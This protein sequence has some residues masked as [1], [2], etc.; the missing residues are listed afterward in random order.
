MTLGLLDRVWTKAEMGQGVKVWGTE[1][2][3]IGSQ[4]IL[5]EAFADNR[6]REGE[7]DVP[8]QAQGGFGGVDLVVRQ[9][10]SLER[11]RIDPRRIGKVA[12]AQHVNGG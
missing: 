3:G 7:A 11:S 6:R 2:L 8:G 5:E 9:P 4:D 1:G 10:L 12:M